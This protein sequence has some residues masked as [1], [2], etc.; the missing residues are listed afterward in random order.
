[1]EA[2]D[3]FEATLFINSSVIDM[4]KP[5]DHAFDMP[6]RAKRAQKQQSETVNTCNACLRASGGTGE[7]NH[8]KEENIK[9]F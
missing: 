6:K 3:S 9:M 1:M 8:C 2:D 7:H 5:S 4:I